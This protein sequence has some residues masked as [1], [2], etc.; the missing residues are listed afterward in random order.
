[1]P[2]ESLEDVQEDAGSDVPAVAADGSQD[3]AG[4]EGTDAGIDAGCP[5]GSSN[6]GTAWILDID[7]NAFRCYL[8]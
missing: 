3:D 5:H 7:F 8:S 1:M 4:R 2:E 6:E